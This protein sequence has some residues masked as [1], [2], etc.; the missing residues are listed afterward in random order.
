MADILA[1]LGQKRT[2]KVKRITRSRLFTGRQ[3]YYYLLS[4]STIL[5]V[6]L[7]LPHGNVM[8]R[9]N[10]LDALSW[11]FYCGNS[12]RWAAG[13]HPANKYDVQL[14]E[15]HHAVQLMQGSK[16]SYLPTWCSPGSDSAVFS[17]S[18]F[19]LSAKPMLLINGPGKIRDRKFPNSELHFL[20]SDDLLVNSALRAQRT[21]SC[22]LKN[23]RLLSSASLGRPLF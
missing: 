13:R 16:I 15:P 18:L 6:Q 3:I 8:T 4:G 7:P 2:D 21:C 12:S 19:M 14:I 22:T 9:P 23:R 5:P 20:N 17:L 10:N 11:S 1:S